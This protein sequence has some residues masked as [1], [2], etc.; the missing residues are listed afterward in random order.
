MVTARP[1]TSH[2]LDTVLDSVEGARF[3]FK[4]YVMQGGQ[5][6]CDVTVVYDP[7]GGGFHIGGKWWY[8]NGYADYMY[9][10]D[11]PDAPVSLVSTVIRAPPP[12]PKKEKKPKVDQKALQSQ[13]A[14]LSKVTD[15]AEKAAKLDALLAEMA[16]ATVSK[17]VPPAPVE[18]V[19]EKEKEVLTVEQTS[20]SEAPEDNDEWADIVDEDP[21]PPNSPVKRERKEVQ[22]QVGDGGR[23]SLRVPSTVTKTLAGASSSEVKKMLS[24]VQ[25]GGYAS[26][27]RGTTPA[28]RGR[29]ARRG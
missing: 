27:A 5:A 12:P 29:G 17:T 4:N 1:K 14:E 10:E 23:S 16:A 8:H 21:T 11:A 13:L 2:D 28:K 18:K 26:A 15:V 24:Q 20:E 22:A 9:K 3:L 6:V 7:T 25:K 19:V